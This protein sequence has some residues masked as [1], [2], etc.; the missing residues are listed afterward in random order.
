VVEN[1]QIMANFN[2][3]SYDVDTDSLVHESV[4]PSMIL[5]MN[6][7]LSSP[8]QIQSQ[9]TSVTSSS[10]TSSS[11]GFLDMIHIEHNVQPYQEVEKFVQVCLSLHMSNHSRSSQ[12][13]D[14][15]FTFV[16]VLAMDMVTVDNDP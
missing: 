2:D 14:N 4:P 12:L 8:F 13:V 10:C 5:N 16:C 15:L 1:R 6:E 3:V 9:I 7:E 11:A